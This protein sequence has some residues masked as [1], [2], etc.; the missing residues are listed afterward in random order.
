M[1]ENQEGMDHI[2]EVVKDLSSFARAG[3]DKIVALDL[4]DV[5]RSACNLVRN[6]LRHRAELV[7]DLQSCPPIVGERSRLIQLTVNLLVNAAHAVDEGPI[8]ENRVTVRTGETDDGVGLIV[9][10]T[11]CGIPPEN[12]EKIFEPFFTT[13][14]QGR[15]TGL[16]LSLCAE[17]ARRHQGSLRVTSRVGQGSR[18]SLMLPIET[19]LSVSIPSGPQQP[20]SPEI[21]LRVLV[22]DDEHHLGSAIAR[23]MAPVH[24][25][26]VAHDGGQALRVLAEDSAFDAILCDVMM[27]VVDGPRFHAA[28]TEA[29]P[30]MV[31][32]VVF[33]TGEAFTPRARAFLSAVPNRVLSKPV[34]IE[35]V[36]EALA[37]VAGPPKPNHW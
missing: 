13:R 34:R 35:A 33:L 14:G 12:L 37:L 16:G 5:A 28:L 20:M 6:E 18:F 23:A 19:G 21:P 24:E 25:V 8:G 29:H 36:V 17:T 15:G 26:V 27:P 4:A 32:R 3:G 10:D 1:T 7:L 31:D 9:E 22:V 11:G 30:D 2:R